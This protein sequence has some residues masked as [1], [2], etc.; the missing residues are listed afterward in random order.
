[1][2]AAPRPCTACSDGLVVML[3]CSSVC[4]Q[5]KSETTEARKQYMLILRRPSLGLTVGPNGE[6]RSDVKS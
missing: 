6:G 2:H 4:L 3:V 5:D 1:M